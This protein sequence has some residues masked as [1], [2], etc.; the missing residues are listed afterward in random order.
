[1][2]SVRAQQFSLGQAPIAEIQI[3]PK[4][5]DD[6]PA[7][8][9]GLQALY[10]HLPTRSKVFDLLCAHF[11]NLADLDRGRPGMGFWSIFVLATL[12][13]GLGCDFDRLTYLVNDMDSVRQMLGLDDQVGDRVIFQRQTIIDNISKLT[14]ELLDEVNQIVVIY[15]HQEVG[16]AEELYT[17]ADSFVVETDVH[18][19][20]R[21]CQILGLQ[22]AAAWD[23]GIRIRRLVCL[24][25]RCT[26]VGLFPTHG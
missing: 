7:I 18:W 24:L 25:L 6:I 20:T 16:A 10:T 15:G 17:R 3:D 11:A 23:W 8:L 26:R 13:Q 1:M 2:R 21:N 22:S 4:S 5:R 14:P 19:P 12:K 9:L